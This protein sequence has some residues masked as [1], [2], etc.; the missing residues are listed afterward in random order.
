MALPW[1]R[2]DTN[3]PSH[4]KILQLLSDPSPKKWQACTS[5][6]FSLAWAGGAG[7]DGHIPTA[8]LPFVHGTPLTARLLVKYRLWEEATAG[9]QIRNYDARQELLLVSEAKRA[10]KRAG[11]I[12][13]N[14]IKYH[15]KDCGCWRD[16]L[17]GLND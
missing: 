3:I 10:A 4:D 5:Y 11:G 2:L 16:N 15:G 12:K 9:F 6:M 14:C 13:G 8:A 1:V 17:G 7:S